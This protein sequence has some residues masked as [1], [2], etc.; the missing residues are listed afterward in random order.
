VLS[1]GGGLVFEG[2]V[3]GSFGA[4]DARKGSLLWSFPAQSGIIAAPMSYAVGK[5][6]YVAIVV[7]WG[8]S[9]PLATGEIARKGSMAVNRSRVLAFRLGGTAQLPSVPAQSPPEVQAKPPER[10]GNDATRAEGMALFQH[11]CSVCHGDAVVGAG[12]VPDLRWSSALQA[13]DKWQRI[14]RDGALRN[15]GMVAFAEVLTLEQAEAIRAYVTGRANDT[16][17]PQ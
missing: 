14:V 4:Y 16:Y 2:N 10:F 9:Y 8:G 13:S 1:T 12:V 6:Q 7:G 5:D 11:Y 15:H 3:A 17:R